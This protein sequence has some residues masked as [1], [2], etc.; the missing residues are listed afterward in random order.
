MTEIEQVL[1]SIY[2]DPSNPASFTTVEKLY[3]AAKEFLPKLT[4]NDVTKWLTG[5]LTYTLHKSVR[6]RFKRN[7]IVVEHIDQQWEA[8]LVDMQ[9][10]AS[11]NNGNNYILTVVDVM[12]KYAWVKELKDKRMK[13]I[14]HAFESIFKDKRLPKF[15]R[16]DQGKEFVNKE[17][18]KFLKECGVHHFTSK[19]QT[20]KCAIVER[21]NRTLKDRMYKYFTANGNRIWFDVLPELVSAY[22]NSKHRTIR[23]TPVEASES[24]NEIL[25]KNMYG[26]DNIEE[27][28]KVKDEHRLKEGDVVRKTYKLGPFDKSFYPN[29]TDKTYK[30]N[31]IA[32]EPVKAMYKIED[33]KKEID[34]Q[35][36]YPEE[37]Q[38]ITENLYR[39]EK[40]INRKTVGGKKM[41]LVKWLNYPDSFNSWVEEKNIVNIKQN[42]KRKVN[43]KRAID[44]KQKISI[45]D[46]SKSL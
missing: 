29:W 37:I 26:F 23:M 5:E 11:Q 39:V 19:N 12:S 41:C 28:Y 27:L 20:I 9:E 3:N 16:T 43:E 42:R 22:N 32:K 7:P 31:A 17:F 35:R 24:K 2:Y 34:K 25:F 40:I 4:L 21:F 10:F 44:E 18:K 6:R 8:D 13:S 15:I 36:Y 33:E 30:V 38:K 45:S 46:T 14:V 1:R